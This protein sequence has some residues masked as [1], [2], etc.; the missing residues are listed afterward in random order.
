MI[1]VRLLLI[2]FDLLLLPLRALRRKAA[3]P[4]GAFVAIEIDG[5]VTDLAPKPRFWEMRAQKAT[6]LWRV[7]EI[8]DAAIADARVRGVLV[9]LKDFGGGLASAASLRAHLARA[10]AAGKE[11]V[12][13]LPM[14]GGSKEMLAASGASKI[15]L[16]PATQLAPLGF[17]SSTRYLRRALDRAGVA[18]DV[19]A[20]GKYKSAGENLTRESMSAPQREQLD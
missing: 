9:V 10:R 6:S 19:I 4:G 17:V 12:A 8:I 15:V 1:L 3:V 13:Y 7:S 11:V 5:P 14:G 2:L 18:P 20:A 16:A